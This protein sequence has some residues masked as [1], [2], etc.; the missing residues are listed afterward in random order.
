MEH[1]FPFSKYGGWDNINS[2]QPPFILPVA[3]GIENA[4]HIKFSVYLK[5]SDFDCA[6]LPGGWGR[7]CSLS[8]ILYPGRQHV[9]KS[10]QVI[11]CYAK[12]KALWYHLINTTKE[13]TYV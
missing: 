12:N 1:K 8:R 3:D 7:A 10:V 9:T 11:F 5:A 6:C 13:L 2:S 4:L